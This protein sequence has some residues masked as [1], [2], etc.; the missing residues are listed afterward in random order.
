MSVTHSFAHIIATIL[1]FL[2]VAIPLH[3]FTSTSSSS[4]FA[5]VLTRRDWLLISEKVLSYDQH[6]WNSAHRLKYRIIAIIKEGTEQYSKTLIYICFQSAK[7]EIKWRWKLLFDLCV[8]WWSEHTNKRIHTKH[9]TPTNHSNQH[10]LNHWAR[11]VLSREVNFSTIIT[12]YVNIIFTANVFPLHSVW[13]NHV[14][15]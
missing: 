12:Q 1:L 9:K 5:L 4:S 10:A 3:I 11:R 7:R 15:R 14:Y 6:N 8:R 2:R 13:I